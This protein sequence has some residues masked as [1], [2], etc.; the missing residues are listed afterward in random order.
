MSEIEILERAFCILADIRTR[1]RNEEGNTEY[2][3]LLR[4]T[5]DGLFDIIEKEVKEDVLYSGS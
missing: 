2:S 4:K 1:E 5:M 3:M